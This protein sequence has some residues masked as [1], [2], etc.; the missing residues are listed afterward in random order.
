MSYV[1]QYNMSLQGM[2]KI[3]KI[4]KQM[5]P[6]SQSSV[7]QL[8]LIINRCCKLVYLKIQKTDNILT[9]GDRKTSC[10]G[11]NQIWPSGKDVY[12]FIIWH[13]FN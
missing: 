10:S 12:I 3:S 2:Q 5:E 9:G 7:R 4:Q 6:H 8:V 1:F 11:L 13:I